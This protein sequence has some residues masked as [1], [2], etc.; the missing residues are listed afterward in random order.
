[1]IWVLIA[2]LASLAVLALVLPVMRRD[3]ADVTRRG[4]GVFAGQLDE[5]KRDLEL[6]LVEPEAAQAAEREIRRREAAAEAIGPDAESVRPGLRL[7]LIL[8]SVAASML[9]VVIY[10]AIG[11]PFL[12]GREAPAQPEMPQEI[13][14]VMAEIDALAADLMANPDNPQ[15]WAVL[16]QAYTTLGRYSEAV[17]A[18]E[19]AINGVPDSAFLFSA[20]GQAYLFEAQGTVTPAAREAFSRAL[21][22]DPTDVRARF[23]L[24]EAQYQSGNREAALAAWQALLED[25]PDDAGY[26]PMIEDRLAAAREAPAD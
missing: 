16:G 7:S 6:G 21:D 19:N 10:M 4:L 9:A 25:A 15:G 13:Q 18:F 22:L 24:A 1:M 26:R 23:F 5:L 17:V 11:S 2:I 12:V 14:A 8:S 3:S 20:L